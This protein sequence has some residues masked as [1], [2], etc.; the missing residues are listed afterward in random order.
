MKERIHWVSAG[1]VF[2][3]T[4]DID[5]T[6]CARRVGKALDQ[7]G[8]RATGTR[9]MP[10]GSARI[11]SCCHTL[12]ISL[13]RDAPCPGLTA[14]APLC[15]QVAVA[16]MPGSARTDRQD[17]TR[18]MLVTHLLKE[19]NAQLAA[20]YVRW[21]GDSRLMSAADFDLITADLP[22][23]PIIL[24]G[25]HHAHDDTRDHDDALA[26]APVPVPAPIEPSP[27]AHPGR[28]AQLDT[29][30]AFLRQLDAEDPRE[31]APDHAAA[32]PSDLQRL[33][34]WLM[35]FAVVLLALPIGLMLVLLNLAKGENPRLAYQA[36]ALTG[37]F[38]ALQSQGN[39][40]EAMTVMVSLLS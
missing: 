39:T 2:L 26:P 1:L 5:I 16:D 36:A 33:S 40:A 4:R 18:D 11:T 31:T 37:M 21:V 8:H 32:R 20:D 12:R 27:H 30:R 29:L 34:A 6:D 17:M 22:A 23:P 13:K 35:S 7:L 3:G 28:D 9:I 24:G 14:P 15:M 38:I 25:H 19:L 10:E